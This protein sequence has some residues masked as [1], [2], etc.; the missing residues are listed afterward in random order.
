MY[1]KGYSFE[2]VT[3][4]GSGINYK[5]KGFLYLVDRVMSGD[6][7]KIVVLYKDRFL[8]FGFDLVEHI[9]QVNQTDIKIIDNTPKTEQE[10]LVEDLVQ[11]I[12]VF[13]S[14]LQGKRVKKTKELISSL[15]EG[16]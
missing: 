6:V 9:C 13:S 10:E 1:A 14:K 7:D 11:I 3:T 8:R 5:R 16:D 12:T 2:L 4:I 15:K